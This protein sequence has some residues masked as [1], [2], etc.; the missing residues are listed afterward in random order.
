MITDAAHRDGPPSPDA[1]SP[2]FWRNPWAIATVVGIATITL[3]RPCTRYVPPPPAVIGEVPAY[4]LEDDQGRGFGSEDLRG[5]VYVLAFFS[6]GCR[7][8]ECNRILPAL[9]DLEEKSG[10]ADPPIP[11]VAISIDWGKEPAALQRW[12]EVNTYELVRTRF[13][14]GTAAVATLLLDSLARLEHSPVQKPWDLGLIL[15][16]GAGRCR[17]FYGTRKEHGVD[18]VAHRAIHVR[19]ED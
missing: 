8:D 4:E 9:K 5:Q 15:V 17:G 12:V 10:L 19:S 3:M 14:R 16:D 13:L 7:G 1:P 11:I 6:V 18:E 2:P